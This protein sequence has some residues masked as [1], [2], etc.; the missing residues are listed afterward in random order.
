MPVNLRTLPLLL[1]AAALG[2]AEIGRGQVAVVYNA[3]SWAS[4]TV[5]QAW[6]RL[7]GIP[8]EQAIAVEGVAWRESMALDDCQRLIFAP[9]DAELRRRGLA[10]AVAVI[11]YA[12]DLPLALGFDAPGAGNGQRG[13]ASLTGM[14]LLAP[15]IRHGWQAFTAPRANPY[16]EEL[17][18]PAA[19]LDQRAAA[20][21]RLAAAGER[22]TAKDAAGAERLL[23]ALAADVPAAGV[24]YDLACAQALQ[25]RTGDALGTLR[26]AV[27]AGWMDERHSAADPDLAPLRADPA[28]PALLAGMGDQAAL[29]Q[30]GPSPGFRPIAGPAGEA[31]PPGRLAMV[32]AVTSGRGLAVDTAVERLAASAAADGSRPTGTVW[33]MA[34]TDAARTGP[35]AWAFRAAATALRAA[36]V[37][38]EIRDG[39][40]PPRDAAVAGAMVGAADFSWEGSGAT[41][42]SGAWC[43]HLTSYGG[44]L[45]PGAGQTPLTAWLRA[46]AAGAGGAVAEPFNI[47]LKFPSA[48]LHLHRVR[49]LSLV[50]AVHRTMP[51]PF[52]YLAVGDPLS[53]PWAEREPLPAARRT[54]AGAALHLPPNAVWG[55]TVSARAAAPGGGTLVITHLGRVI[56][57]GGAGALAID[58]RRLGIGPCELV[59]GTAAADGT[60]TRL[61]AALLVVEPPAALPALPDPGPTAPGAAEG[62]GWIQIA[63]GGLHQVQWSSGRMQGVTWD[64]GAELAGTGGPGSEPVLLLPG[65]HRLRIRLAP[66]SEPCELRFGREG[67]AP[68]DAGRWRRAGR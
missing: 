34:S 47:A 56:A 42:L 41:L 58:T 25:G 9:V 65:W 4:R 19:A 20:D 7:R 55:A 21:P 59:L 24:L 50:E 10:D 2:A 51:M 37:A 3:D 66:G 60:V 23:A 18:G 27:A 43:D 14:T 54:V 5:A 44:A 63:D 26:R 46:G 64:G 13:P 31:G 36:G 15:L 35:R 1:L 17:R 48:F 52:Q 49:G 57:R 67:T 6:M 53:R 38:A 40:L 68:L 32:L 61:T 39:V 22:F 62:E 11:A 29:V 16:A 45:E 30:A 33:F 12:P 28:W 8:A